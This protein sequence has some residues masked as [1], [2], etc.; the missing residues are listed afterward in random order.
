MAGVDERPAARFYTRA[1]RFPVMIGRFADGTRLP[2]GPYTFPQIV[3][4]AI[5]LL[6]ALMTRGVWSRGNSLVDVLIAV[7][8]AIG[9]AIM[10]GKIPAMHRSLTSVFFGMIH[11]YTRPRSGNYAGRTLA[12]RRPY[13]AAGRHL[14]TPSAPQL[15]GLDAGLAPASELELRPVATTD[16]AIAPSPIAPAVTTPKAVS[17]V[18]RLLQLT[19][20]E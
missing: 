7:A 12:F 15:E 19:R 13:R 8:V 5:A 3:S 9:V 20:S 2:G 4:A 14:P 17:S 10:V 18:E 11:A 1:R 6:I 16:V